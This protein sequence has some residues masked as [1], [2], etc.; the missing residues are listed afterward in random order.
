V[1]NPTFLSAE[2][3]K[4]AIANYAID[5]GL[6]LN[7]LPAGTEPDLWKGRCY[8][9]LV[10]FMFLNTRIKGFAVPCH[11]NFEE[12]N[13]RFYVRFGKGS[14]S[15]RGVVFIKELVPR[16]A[17]TM[18]ANRMYKENYQTLP[19]RHS[20]L[21]HDDEIAI[22][23]EWRKTEWH[24][25]EVRVENK[26]IPIEVNSEE[27]F[28]TEHYWGYTKLNETLTSEYEVQHPRWNTYRVKDH[29]I[30]VDFGMVYGQQLSFLNHLAPVSVMLAEGS[31]V[32]V[33]SGT[34]HK[35]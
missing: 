22:K 33:K 29:S 10:G 11:I 8:V 13:L 7:Y 17:L 27:E 5:P 34:I 6:L 21:V 23:Y 12:V 2:W 31:P 32:S 20:W 25:F 28:I 18:V 1:S 4:L 16:P 26:H 35:F 24:S 14:E 30:K 15:K 19:M 3:R 9:S